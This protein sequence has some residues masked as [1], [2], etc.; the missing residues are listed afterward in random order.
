MHAEKYACSRVQ[1]GAGEILNKNT[2]SG[3]QTVPPETCRGV[4][5]L[6][7]HFLLL[8]FRGYFLCLLLGKNNKN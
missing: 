6:D 7:R 5:C 2:I 3:T 4:V 1:I 8:F